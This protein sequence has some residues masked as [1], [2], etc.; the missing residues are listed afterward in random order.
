MTDQPV[1]VR[2]RLT[3]CFTT[4]FPELPV[5]QISSASTATIQAWDSLAHITLLSAISEDLQ[6]DLETED[7]ERLTSFAA[8]AD[9]AEQK[10]AERA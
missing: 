4:V 1:S 3:E 8:I 2:D 9:F 5:E 10:L 7:F 6:I